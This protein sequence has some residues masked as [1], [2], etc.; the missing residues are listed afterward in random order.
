LR[1]L[2]GLQGE[3]KTVE[4]LASRVCTKW[5]KVCPSKEVPKSY[6]RKDEYWMPMDEDSFKMRNMEKTMQR[7]TKKHGTQPVKFVD[8]MGGMMMGSDGWDEEEDDMDP[9]ERMMAQMGGEL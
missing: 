9:M 1:L 2:P 4:K 3:P 6:S 5:S 7:M 8:P